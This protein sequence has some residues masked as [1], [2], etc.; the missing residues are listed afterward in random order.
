MT[1]DPTLPSSYAGE[2]VV[3]IVGGGVAAF[4]TA[5]LA[6]RL[7]QNGTG[8]SVV[9]TAAGARFVGSPTFA[10]ITGRRVATE[11]FD[12]HFPLGAHIELARRGDVLCIAP[13]TADFAAKAA[14]GIADDLASTLM[15]SFQGP[16]VAAPAMNSAMWAKPSV[17]RN[18]AQLRADGVEVVGPAEGWL[19][20]RDL[21]AGRMAEPEELLVA[22]ERKLHVE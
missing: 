19:S 15:L 2:E 13:M 14:H 12:P 10:A 22:V 9:L 4:K 11:M 1:S 20:C 3:L 16:V 21:G 7:V 6:S 18:M 17:Q 5:T 8:V